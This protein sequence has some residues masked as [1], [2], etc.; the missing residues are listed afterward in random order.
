MFWLRYNH[1]HHCENR[2][3]SPPQLAAGWSEINV[4]A[5]WKDKDKAK[6]RWM[7]HRTIILVNIIYFNCIIATAIIAMVYYNYQVSHPHSSS[8]SSTT[9]HYHYVVILIVHDLYSSRFQQIVDCRVGW[10]PTSYFHHFHNAFHSSLLP[11]PPGPP[12][13]TQRLTSP[14]TYWMI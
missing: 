3:P 11:P 13:N 9:I 4:I 12:P 1:I 2:P 5:V 8:S 14:C 6:M 7:R 10:S